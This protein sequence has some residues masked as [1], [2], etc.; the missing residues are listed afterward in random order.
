MIALYLLGCLTEEL[1]ELTRFHW[2]VY[3]TRNGG[4]MS[5]L[6][7]EVHCRLLQIVFMVV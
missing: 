7:Y 5:K 2:R 6:G 3:F 4:L 1:A